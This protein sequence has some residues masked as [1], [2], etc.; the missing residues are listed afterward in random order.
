M[1]LRRTKT[2]RLQHRKRPETS[3]QKPPSDGIARFYADDVTWAAPGP[4]E[5]THAIIED[6]VIDL[7]VRGGRYID[8]LTRAPSEGGPVQVTNSDPNDTMRVT[9]TDAEGGEVRFPEIDPVPEPYH[10]QYLN[11]V[12]V[13]R[14]HNRS[15]ET[16]SAVLFDND[17]TDRWDILWMHAPH[18]NPVHIEHIERSALEDAVTGGRSVTFETIHRAM[19]LG[20]DIALS[21]EERQDIL[22]DCFYLPSD[23]PDEEL[24]EAQNSRLRD[25][26]QGATVRTRTATAGESPGAP[27]AGADAA[28]RKSIAASIAAASHAQS[29]R[30]KRDAIHKSYLNKYE[31]FVRWRHWQSWSMSGTAEHYGGP[32]TFTERGPISLRK[33]STQIIVIY[34]TLLSWFVGIPGYELL[35]LLN[36]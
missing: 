35:Q 3:K 36:Q 34:W 21:Y 23:A 24:I 28:E 30:M 11:G 27:L 5:A 12:P 2:G 10:Y 20:A 7:R 26:T 15:G 16:D 29:I 25:R 32:L 1:I 22:D 4:I 31:W 13:F 19:H 14:R 18:L 6:E 8:H 17:M 9:F 33:W